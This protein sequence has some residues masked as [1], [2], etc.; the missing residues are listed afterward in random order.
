MKAIFVIYIAAGL[1]LFFA[2]L[3]MVAGA[4]QAYTIHRAMAMLHPTGDDL[5]RMQAVEN[6]HLDSAEENF[7]LAVLQ[8]AIIIYARKLSKQPQA[9]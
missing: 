5:D 1:T 3:N 4:G 7:A 8:G 2:V 6:A 9:A